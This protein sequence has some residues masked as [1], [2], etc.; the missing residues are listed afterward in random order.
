MHE[1]EYIGDER[2]LV[3]NN[4]YQGC[5]QM[6]ISLFNG[7]FTPNFNSKSYLYAN[8]FTQLCS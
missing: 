1:D 5:D 4:G 6:S 3:N 2:L 8:E 7:P